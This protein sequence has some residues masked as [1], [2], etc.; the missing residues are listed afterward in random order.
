MLYIYMNA[1]EAG[2]PSDLLLPVEYGRIEI[3]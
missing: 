1:L 2:Y 3:M